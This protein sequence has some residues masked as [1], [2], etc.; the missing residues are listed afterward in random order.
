M[1]GYQLS[2][3]AGAKIEFSEYSGPELIERGEGGTKITKN[4]IDY[5]TSGKPPR[6]YHTETC[7]I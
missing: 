2:K 1:I 4:G 3:K 6:R 7:G 5:W